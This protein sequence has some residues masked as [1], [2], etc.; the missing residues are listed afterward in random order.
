MRTLVSRVEGGD[1]AMAHRLFEGKEHAEAY[2]R[3]RVSPSD[4]LIQQVVDFVEKKVRL[5]TWVSVTAQHTLH[6][7]RGRLGQKSYLVSHTLL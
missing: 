7:M 5:S 6:N 2:L 4:H 3:F 1:Q